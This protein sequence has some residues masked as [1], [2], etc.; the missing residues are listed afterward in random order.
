MP[1]N[2][3]PLVIDPLPP[4]LSDG[5]PDLPGPKNS[6]VID[7]Q[8]SAFVNYLAKLS[9]VA[10]DLY[11]HNPSLIPN[12]DQSVLLEQGVK[13]PESATLSGLPHALKGTTAVVSAGDAKKTDS[14]SSRKRTASGGAR[15]ADSAAA[16]PDDD[17]VDALSEAAKKKRRV[18]SALPASGSSKSLLDSSTPTKPSTNTS[19]KGST[20]GLSKVSKAKAK[21]NDPVR[22][23]SMER[24]PVWF[25]KK[26]KVEEVAKSEAVKPLE[27]DIEETAAPSGKSPKHVVPEAPETQLSDAPAGPSRQP[28]IASSSPTPVQATTSAAT[29][30]S[31]SKPAQLSTSSGS[32]SASSHPLTVDE[33]IETENSEDLTKVTISTTTVSIEGPDHVNLNKILPSMVT[34]H[35]AAGDAPDPSSSDAAT[36]TASSS[37]P[38][39]SK[40]PLMKP[41]STTSKPPSAAAVRSK[42]RSQSPTKA[43]ASGGP[44]AEPAAEPSKPAAKTSST[45]TTASTKP[46]SP[47]PPSSST[48]AKAPVAS[49]PKPAFGLPPGEAMDIDETPPVTFNTIIP[50][51]ATGPTLEVVSDTVA[52]DVDS[53]VSGKKEEA[54]PLT[55]VPTAEKPVAPPESSISSATATS[56]PSKKETQ[57]SSSTTATAKP[58]SSTTATAKPSQSTAQASST[59]KLSQSSGD[60]SEKKQAL[61]Q[62][63]ASTSAKPSQASKLEH[64]SAAHD[65]SSSTSNPT[66][67]QTKS[68]A[69]VVVGQAKPPAT[70]DLTQKQQNPSPTLTER[71]ASPPSSTVDPARQGYQQEAAKRNSQNLAPVQL[72]TAPDQLKAAGVV[73]GKI[74]PQKTSLTI[75][76]RT[77]LE[78]PSIP[79]QTAAQPQHQ[80]TQNKAG[81]N[82]VVKGG[83]SQRPWH[84][85]PKKEVR[86]SSF[87]AE[88]DEP[89]MQ[90]TFH[91]LAPKPQAPT[92][93]LPHAP[94]ASFSAITSVG[95]PLLQPSSAPF[96]VKQDMSSELPQHITHS[97]TLNPRGR[98]PKDKYANALPPSQPPLSSFRMSPS[99]INQQAPHLVVQTAPK[100]LTNQPTATPANI[101]P[102]APNLT[103]QTPATP[104]I[105]TPA[106]PN[107]TNQTPATPAIIT[108]AAPKL[109]LTN[110]PIF[111]RNE[112]VWVE[113]VV[114]VDKLKRIN[115]SFPGKGVVGRWSKDTYIIDCSFVSDDIVLWP[116]IVNQV[117]TSPNPE[118]PIWST[119][120]VVEARGDKINVRSTH[121]FVD[122]AFAA[123]TTTTAATTKDSRQQNS[124]EKTAKRVL[125]YRPAYSVKLLRVAD[126]EM[127]FSE[128][129]IIPFHA[130]DFSRDR[131]IPIIPLEVFLNFE[132]MC[133]EVNHLIV[134]GYLSA[135][136][137]AILHVKSVVAIP[138][139][140]EN[141]TYASP[142]TLLPA[143]GSSTNEAVAKPKGLMLKQRIYGP[144]QLGAE[145]VFRKDVLRCINIPPTKKAGSFSAVE[146]L[147]RVDHWDLLANLE[148]N[149]E[150]LV[151]VG[152]LVRQSPTVLE[153]A[154]RATEGLGGLNRLVG[155]VPV[156]ELP[157]APL[158]RVKA[159]KILGRY[160]ESYWEVYG[161]LDPGRVVKLKNG[162]WEP[163]HLKEGE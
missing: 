130:Y 109:L 147:L 73:G 83:T 103:N 141:V 122:K 19:K 133:T 92:V 127:T 13:V 100:N 14:G 110:D 76:E 90:G 156:E 26:D 114:K 152:Q 116:A 24:M 123:R 57:P 31:P 70:T 51:L 86:T 12:I 89:M 139:H 145:I 113:A 9:A 43:A 75:S 30:T 106:A 91:G 149:E 49:P 94:P 134:S 129:H 81:A 58:S 88:F 41:S 158:V 117:R 11:S 48:P 54:K 84:S 159:E 16:A 162:I 39:P 18:T 155:G 96:T 8:D 23:S 6:Y 35:V 63:V 72:Q 22:S 46:V 128:E 108:P 142:T 25:T 21:A 93:G 78:S 98:I 67:S 45:S 37:K 71:N 107:L 52:M 74:K 101:T 50:T 140:P 97:S 153:K 150:S 154:I 3:A 126:C 44:A 66:T 56:D 53:S 65:A 20:S 144:V 32:T 61:S 136:S 151:A 64:S 34:G 124:D 38:T 115:F 68:P 148:N 59:S 79:T 143:A 111:R 131:Q 132:R 146:S 77:G 40:E 7:S 163:Y 137:S 119:P 47:A 10:A 80:I 118:K 55:S 105:I 15:V 29:A 157:G 138:G 36:K 121:S 5:V 135:V 28:P 104:A 69:V 42:S 102:G 82:I 99:T 2:D 33:S 120:V 87:G 125:Y 112:I 160:Y 17:F 4:P 1:S 95:V 85:P 161:G 60:T 27:A 62:A